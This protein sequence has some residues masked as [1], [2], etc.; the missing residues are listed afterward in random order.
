MHRGAGLAV[1]ADGPVATGTTV[2]LA[3]PLPLGHAL[4]ACRIVATVD[5]PGERFGFAYGTLPLHPE[6]GEEAFIVTRDAAGGATFEIRVFWRPHHVLAKLGAP[7][8]T[9]LQR[10]ATGRYLDAM[11]RRAGSRRT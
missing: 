6:E 11:V 1:A 4:A 8:A 9:R 5:D 10:Q 7:V 2:V 3:A